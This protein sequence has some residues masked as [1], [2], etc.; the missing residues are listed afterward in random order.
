MLNE[1]HKNEK[2]FDFKNWDK[3][4]G[5]I[6]TNTK[7]CA[8]SHTASEE[9]NEWRSGYEITNEWILNNIE[10]INQNQRWIETNNNYINTIKQIGLM[11]TYEEIYETK[12]DVDRIKKYIGMSDLKYEHLLDSN[13]RLRNRNKLKRKLI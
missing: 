3:I 13:N 4:I 12:D 2:N 8:I 9:R 5:L 7:E 6:R 10:T 1:Y 11:V